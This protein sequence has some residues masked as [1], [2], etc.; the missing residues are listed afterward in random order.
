MSEQQIA[1]ITEKMMQIFR[2]QTGSRLPAEQV[3]KLT[4]MMVASNAKLNQAQQ[5]PVRPTTPEKPKP[6]EFDYKKRRNRTVLKRFPFLLTVKHA[7]TA[8]RDEIDAYL[9]MMLGP[10]GQDWTRTGYS[11]YIFTKK[12]YT[13]QLI[14]RFRGTQ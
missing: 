1:E 11:E 13:V 3:S 9:N 2:A 10:S 6:L 14:V 7:S 5:A 4:A 8:V 12:E